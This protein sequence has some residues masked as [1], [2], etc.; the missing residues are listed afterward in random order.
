MV[1]ARERSPSLE[2]FRRVENSAWWMPRIKGRLIE[3]G[4]FSHNNIEAVL[5][6][7]ARPW[8]PIVGHPEVTN[9]YKA[10]DK[11]ASAEQIDDLREFVLLEMPD[12]F[13]LPLEGVAVLPVEPV[14]DSR[15]GQRSRLTSPKIGQVVGERVAAKDAFKKYFKLNKLPRGAMNDDDLYSDIRLGISNRPIRREVLVFMRNALTYE[16]HIPDLANL[17]SGDANPFNCS[18]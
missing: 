8:V 7:L 16:Q 1:D 11:E 9:L 6:P 17:T 15:N 5:K 4:R 14:S 18:D 10:M 2:L 12:S 13:A 3:D